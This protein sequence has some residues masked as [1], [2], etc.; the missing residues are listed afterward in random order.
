[1]L[2]EPRQVFKLS[3]EFIWLELVLYFC[4]RLFELLFIVI[5]GDRSLNNGVDLK[6]FMEFSIISMIISITFSCCCLK[7]EYGVREKLKIQ[8]EREIMRELE[9]LENIIIDQRIQDDV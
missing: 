1:M 3:C 8:H 4:V 5:G 6:M 2:Y 7:W 9:K